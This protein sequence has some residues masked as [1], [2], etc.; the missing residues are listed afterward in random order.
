MKKLALALLFTAGCTAA[1]AVDL[2]V[3]AGLWETR[4]IHNVIDGKDMAPQLNA[5]MAQQQA[6][7]Q[8][9]MANMTP[10]QRAQMMSQMKSLA[11]NN[12]TT[13]T[14]LSPT[15]AAKQSALI[16]PEGHCSAISITPSGMNKISFSFTCN[17]DGNTATGTGT[18]T[19]S[20]DTATLHMDMSSTGNNGKHTMQMDS[21]MTYLGADCQGV[22]PIDEVAKSMQAQHK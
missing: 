21:E 3:K 16:D 9:A 17:R 6:K 2:G 8:A 18:R 13:R 10:E 20:G 11:G 22:L 1:H 12:G 4:M 14:C 5:L 15:M 19:V 7:M